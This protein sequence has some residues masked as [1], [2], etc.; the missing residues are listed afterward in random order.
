M[1][2]SEGPPVSVCLIAAPRSL[3]FATRSRPFTLAPLIQYS[4]LTFLYRPARLRY[5]VAVTLLRLASIETWA[6]YASAWKDNNPQAAIYTAQI[7]LARAKLAGEAAVKR[8]R[9]HVKGFNCKVRGRG[10]QAEPPPACC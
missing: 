9:T 7:S 1:A 2:V 3:L 5:A 10:T 8:K 6:A 4:A